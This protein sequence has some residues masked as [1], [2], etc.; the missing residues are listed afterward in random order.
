MRKNNP[1]QQ[2]KIV[3]RN[4]SSQAQ[5]QSILLPHGG[6]FS[7]IFPDFHIWILKMEWNVQKCGREKCPMRYVCVCVCV[8]VY[9]KN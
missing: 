7:W 3:P 8:C 9:L 4:W 6:S 5:F 1:E 2:E